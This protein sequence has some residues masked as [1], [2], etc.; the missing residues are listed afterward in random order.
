MASSRSIYATTPC[1]TVDP[2][3]DSEPIHLVVDSIGLK[4]SGEG[5]DTISNGVSK[6]WASN[7]HRSKPI[8]LAF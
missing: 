2:F 8:R 1:R 6:N 5:I 7:H 3:G 4:V